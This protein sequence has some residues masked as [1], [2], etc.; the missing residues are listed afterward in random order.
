MTR[1]METDTVA[2]ASVMS[3]DVLFTC[4][5]VEVIEAVCV[6]A[7]GVFIRGF[8]TLFTHPLASERIR[9]PI[10]IVVPCAGLKWNS[11]HFLFVLNMG[12]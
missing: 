2:F 4:N 9:C 8:W 11:H 5:V 12:S 6:Q 10:P 3:G 7:T 1:C